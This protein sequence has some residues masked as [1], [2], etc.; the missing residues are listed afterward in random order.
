MS[1]IP[2]PAPPADS[3]PPGG[4]GEVLDALAGYRNP[5]S[6]ARLARLHGRGHAL[7]GDLEASAG[8][9]DA[10]TLIARLEREPELA[11]GDDGL[12]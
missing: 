1:A 8:W 3:T 9:R 12:A 7:R 5:V 11:L 6:Q 10:A 2:F 4:V